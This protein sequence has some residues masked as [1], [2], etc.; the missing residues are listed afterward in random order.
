MTPVSY[1]PLP[2]R[3]CAA[4]AGAFARADFWASVDSAEPCRSRRPKASAFSCDQSLVGE[5]LANHA[6]HKTVKSL[7][8]VAGHVAIV[9]P[10]RKFI[11]VAAKMLGTGVVINADQPALH[12]RK[13]GLDA[14]GRNTGSDVFALA[15][16]D[17]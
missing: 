14:V 9:Q 7:Q 1:L 8:R 16:I 15:V 13:N 10:K 4:S 17:A 12:D 2:S 6:G 5:A 11:D 3:S